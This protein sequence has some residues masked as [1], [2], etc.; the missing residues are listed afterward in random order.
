M[1]K[2]RGLTFTF[3][4]EGIAETLRAFGDLPKEANAELREAAKGLAT[5]LARD[6]SAA[7]TRRGGQA[8][9]VAK[10]VKARKDRAPFIVIGGAKRVGH[11]YAGAGKRG[12]RG[13]RATAS[14]LL[15]GSEF[16]AN[17]GSGKYA[18][19]GFNPH[20]GKKGTWIFPTVEANRA[21]IAK[22]WQEAADAI[23]ENWAKGD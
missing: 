15:F 12:G 8:A 16:G 7:G 5:G 1:A 10:T 17:P 3:E 23:A 6:I 9:L 4:A 20:T 22:A 21:E 2:S 11:V 18:P 13:A 19:Y 14:D